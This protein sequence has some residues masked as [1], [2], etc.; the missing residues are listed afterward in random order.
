VSCGYDDA[1]EKEDG[2]I[3]DQ[4][5]PDTAFREFL[6]HHLDVGSRMDEAIVTLLFMAD[7]L[8][9]GRLEYRSFDELMESSSLLTAF[10]EMVGTH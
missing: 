6:A 8:T 4:I 1:G 5:T 7:D 10:A 9:M 3:L 2:P